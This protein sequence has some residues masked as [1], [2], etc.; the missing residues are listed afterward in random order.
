MFFNKTK[1]D[2]CFEKNKI[3][4]ELSSCHLLKLIL[5]HSIQLGLPKQL[6]SDRITSG[7]NATS[8]KCKQFESKYTKRQVWKLKNPPT[9]LPAIVIII[10]F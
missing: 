9:F 8:K 1:N 2:L 3:S 10:F 4:D 7:N 5:G 6:L